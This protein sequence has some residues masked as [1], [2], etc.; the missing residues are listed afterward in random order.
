MTSRIDQRMETVREVASAATERM[1]SAVDG[2]ADQVQDA[3]GKAGPEARRLGE[4]VSAELSRRYKAVDR[5][6]RENAFLM[7]L[8]ALGIGVAIGYLLSRDDD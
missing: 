8:G 5:A 6:G 4:K 3:I 7:A 2:I 1:K